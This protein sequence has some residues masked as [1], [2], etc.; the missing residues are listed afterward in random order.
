MFCWIQMS[1]YNSGFCQRSSDWMTNRFV[2]AGYLYIEKPII[3]PICH[4]LQTSNISS[5]SYGFSSLTSLICICPQ[6]TQLLSFSLSRFFFFFL[7]ASFRIAWIWHTI[8]SILDH[9][10][11]HH[12]L[13]CCHCLFTN[14]FIVYYSRDFVQRR[15]CVC[16]RIQCF[17]ASIY[18]ICL[19]KIYI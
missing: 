14:H 17:F 16:E 18:L 5:A 12:L 4:G 1:F 7:F 6:A 2:Q 15:R 19:K 3:V 9:I 10:I 11:H 8:N 13:F